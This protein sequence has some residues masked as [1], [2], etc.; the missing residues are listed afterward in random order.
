[1]S[2]ANAYLTVAGLDV[3]A[4]NPGYKHILL[5]P[6]PGG[7]LQNASAEFQSLYGKIKSAWKIEEGKLIYDVIVPANTSATI[8][9]PS[10][11]AD[12]VMLNGKALPASVKESLKQKDKGLSLGV[13]SGSYQFSYPFTDASGMLKAAK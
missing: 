6:H 13:G 12:Q 11:Q 8:T 3:D 7:G 4:E 9:L 1:M 5:A 10:A 2:T